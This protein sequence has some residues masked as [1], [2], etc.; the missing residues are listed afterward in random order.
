MLDLAKEDGGSVNEPSYTLPDTDS[1]APEAQPAN[2]LLASQALDAG[3]E[4][5]LPP[6]FLLEDQMIFETRL[7]TTKDLLCKLA[8]VSIHRRIVRADRVLGEAEAI[9]QFE[10]HLTEVATARA[11]ELQADFNGQEELDDE[12]VEL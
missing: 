9:R 3:E 2:T 4:Q 12:D 7:A 5:D 10:E 6:G 8:E 1:P 11:E